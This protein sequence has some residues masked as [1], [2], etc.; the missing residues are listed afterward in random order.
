MKYCLSNQH[1]N[2]VLNKADEIK[3]AYKDINSLI[4]YIDAMPNKTYILEI[5]EAESFKFDIELCKAYAD[6]V[7]F[8]LCLYNL[9][10]VGLAVT[11]GLKWYWGYPISSWYELDGVTKLN[12]C[13]LFLTAPLSMD[14]I[15]VSQKTNIPIRLCPN[16]AY[17]IYIPREDGICGQWV[18]PEDQDRYGE[19][20]TTF[21]FFS[22]TPTQE[23]TLF[24]VYAEDK[25]WPG[26]LNLLIT[27]LNYDIDNRI[28]D[29][30]IIDV[31]LTCGQKCMTNAK[32]KLCPNMFK[33]ASNVRHKFYSSRQK[34][35]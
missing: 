8:I 29:Q 34:E 31:R 27:N 15:K 6:K 5:P 23:A 16:L 1:P 24:K 12:P 7:D 33:Y 32:C 19:F 22:T 14:L 28:I 30:D 25:N 35:D 17:D 10:A 18:R 21:E 26:N 3:V 2:S 4:E 9:H 20:V 13:Y 11:A